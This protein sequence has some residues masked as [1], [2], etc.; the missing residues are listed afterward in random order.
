MNPG[1]GFA[2]ARHRVTATL[3]SVKDMFSLVIRYATTMVTERERPAKQWTST[4]PCGCLR[5]P[6]RNSPH[7]CKA[8]SMSNDGESIA[9]TTLCCMLSGISG[10]MPVATVKTCVI[11]F[12]RS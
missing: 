1:L 5:Q 8:C 6:S 4:R 7:S 11:P 12:A 3:A 10:Q 9:E 2:K